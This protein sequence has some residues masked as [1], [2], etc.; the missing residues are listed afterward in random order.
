MSE[1]YMGWILLATTP[2]ACAAAESGEEGLLFLRDPISYL[3]HGRKG[4]G[5]SRVVRTNLLG[6]KQCLVDNKMMP[7]KTVCIGG[8]VP[9]AGK[10]MANFKPRLPA[11]LGDG[12]PTRL[13]A[14]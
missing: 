8:A 2:K 1:Y 9:T 6:P 13:R 12:V 3:S 5:V 10:P 7:L 11:S 4:A 14:K